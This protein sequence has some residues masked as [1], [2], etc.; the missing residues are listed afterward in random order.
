M[1]A[2]Y[3]RALKKN[4]A[5]QMQAGLALTLGITVKPTGDVEA[6]I[7]TQ[8]NVD[9]VPLF[10]FLAFYQ[11][12]LEILPGAVMNLHGPVHTNGSLYLNSD[13]TL[14]VNELN[15]NIPSVHLSAAGNVY[16]GRKDASTCAGGA[17]REAQGREQRRRARHH[18]R[19]C[20]GAA[21]PR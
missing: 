2:C 3:E 8:F 9:Y 13:A 17:D 15:P 10:Q 20:G 12:D 6:S 21:P 18:E 11:N 7:G 19:R 1:Q 4:A 14:T 5:L 16:R